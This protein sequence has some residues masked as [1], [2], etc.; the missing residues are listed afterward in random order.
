MIVAA[1]AANAADLALSWLVLQQY[2]LGA[3]ANPF[4]AGALS[5]GLLGGV[6][7]KAACL[8]VITAAA[9]LNPKRARLL[10]GLAVIVGVIGAASAWLA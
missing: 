9:A 7:W 4:M 8:S 6:A 10:L 5:F 2:G 1:I 3:E